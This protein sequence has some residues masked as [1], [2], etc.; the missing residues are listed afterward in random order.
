M[1]GNKINLFKILGFQVSV[2]ASWLILFL[3]LTWSLARG[4]FPAYFTDLSN[5][6]YWWMGLIGSCGLFLSIIFHELCHSLVAKKFGIPMRGITLFI[7]GGVSEMYD[8]PPSAKSEFLMAIAGPL[9]SF[10]L[11]GFF[12]FIY[13]TSA[14]AAS[15]PVQGVLLYLSLTNVILA[16]FNLI[17][18]FPMDGGRVLRSAL[19]SLKNNLRWATR[20]SSGTGSFFGFLLIALGILNIFGGNLIGGIWWFLIGIF[21]RNAASVSYKQ[22]LTRKALEGE[23]VKRFMIPNP[24]SVSPSLSLAQLVNDYIY[25]FHYKMFPVVSAGTPVGCVTLKEVKHFPHEEWSRHTVGEISSGNLPDYTISPESD[26]V[27]ALSIMNRT[28]HTRLMVVQDNRLVG[29]V[30]LRDLLK[31]LSIKLDLENEDV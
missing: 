28:G 20:I 2:D 7:F 23:K 17:P 8:E 18:A 19:W 9:S 24:V 6:A 13:L 16:V 30:S 4:L 15:I 5:A 1:F 3:L 29:I 26:A 27:E 11:G 25:K 14:A 21:V 10:F 22:L 12:Y 31:F